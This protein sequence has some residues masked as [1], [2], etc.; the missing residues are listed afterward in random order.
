VYLERNHSHLLNKKLMFLKLLET[1]NESFAVWASCKK[2]IVFIFYFLFFIWVNY[3]FHKLSHNTK[4]IRFWLHISPLWIFVHNEL[5]IYFS[6][7]FWRVPTWIHMAKLPKCWRTW[8][9]KKDWIIHRIL[10][11]HFFFKFF[12]CSSSMRLLQFE[13]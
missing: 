8:C 3:I 2:I 1:Q 9:Q 13:C 6:C 10:D 12:F 7:I 11:F 5:K 4:H